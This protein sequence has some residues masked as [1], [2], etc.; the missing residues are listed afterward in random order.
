[1][2]IACFSKKTAF[3]SKTLKSNINDKYK[4]VLRY[5]R[6]AKNCDL[7]VKVDSQWHAM[8]GIAYARAML[9]T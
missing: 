4:R 9:S 1:M 3:N 7:K 6:V 8:L 5:Y 2:I